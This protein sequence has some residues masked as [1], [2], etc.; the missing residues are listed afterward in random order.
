MNESWATVKLEGEIYH[1]LPI[2][3]TEQHEA[4]FDCWCI[5]DVR[6]FDDGHTMVSH[7]SADEAFMETEIQGH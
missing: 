5:P 4:G 2:I 6:H 3:A 7:F 1:V